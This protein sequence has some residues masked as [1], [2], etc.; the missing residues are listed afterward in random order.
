LPECPVARVCRAV[1]VLASQAPVD[2]IV[3][4]LDA[5]AEYVDPARFYHRLSVLEPGFYGGEPPVPE[6]PEYFKAYPGA[7][8]VPL[9]Q[10]PQLAEVDLFEAVRERRSRRVYSSEPLGLGEVGALLYYTVGVTGR[11]WWGGPKRAYPSAGALQ[12]VEAY[13]VASRVSGVEPGVY[14]YHP[15]LHELELLAAGDYSGALEAACLGQEHVGAAPASVVLTVYYARTLSKYGWRAYR[16]AMMDAGFAGENLYL[17]AEALGLATVAVGAFH[18]AEVC[19]ILG[20]DC[21]WELPVLV[22][23]VGRRP[24]S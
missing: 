2:V 7:P 15:G 17:A 20:V 19:S 5:A 12:P 9:P 24:T 22:F 18:D 13:L 21:V 10:P 23:P 6:F 16:Y 4:A 14:H 8:R 1:E 3:E 11:A